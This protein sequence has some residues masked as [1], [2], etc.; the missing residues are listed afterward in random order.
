MADTRHSELFSKYQSV[1]LRLS[2]KYSEEDIQALVNDAATDGCLEYIHT[3]SGVN[4]RIPVPMSSILSGGVYP[5]DLRQLIS[6][7]GDQNIENRKSALSAW[8]SAGGDINS[9]YLVYNAV[10]NN[11]SILDFMFENGARLS[12]QNDTPIANSCG[13]FLFSR[14]TLQTNKSILAIVKH[15]SKATYL[16]NIFMDLLVQHLHIIVFPQ[17]LTDDQVDDMVALILMCVK[18]DKKRT[19]RSGACPGSN[20]VL[21]RLLLGH[22]I[23]FEINYAIRSGFSDCLAAEHLRLSEKSV[24]T[25]KQITEIREI[26]TE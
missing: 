12:D 26:I 16:G 7:F 19:L 9:H 24:H 18:F 21:A 4:C 22:G 23:M 10:L 20:V 1:P 14:H 5:T 2:D 15:L 17:K 11:P 3:V 8:I 13:I 25:Q 6:G